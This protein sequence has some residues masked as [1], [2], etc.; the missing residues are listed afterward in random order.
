MHPTEYVTREIQTY[1]GGTKL[2]FPLHCH[3]LKIT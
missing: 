2:G 1:G 3:I